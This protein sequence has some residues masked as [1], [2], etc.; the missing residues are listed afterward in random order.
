LPHPP[1]TLRETAR[2]EM[3]HLLACDRPGLAS[4]PV[5]FHEGLAEALVGLQPTPFFDYELSILGSSWVRPLR[6][7]ALK[8]AQSSRPL[9]SVL[10]EQSAEVRY[11]ALACLVQLVLN[12]VHGLMPW[13]DS[14]AKPTVNGFLSRLPSDYGSA[15][16]VPLPHGRELDFYG[17]GKDILMASL[18][19][20]SVLLQVG[21][22]TGVQNLDFD[23]RVGRTGA[24]M[25]GVI[26]RSKA[27]P[28]RVVRVR[29]NTFGAVVA[30]LESLNQANVRAYQ[31]RPQPGAVADWREFS[32]ELVESVD[33]L[34]RLRISSREYERTFPREF[35]PPYTLE[36]YVTD[37]ACQVRADQVLLPPDN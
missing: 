24:A 10:V 16:P 30:S 21:T 13:N 17:G 26:L 25:A 15:D 32:M 3:V 23:L 8:P 12:Q 9:H 18:P 14:Y 37:G 20:E 6:E 22:W 2:H 31:S 7:Y 34:P 19:S 4:A 1:R 29:M 11:S 28:K 5:W 36:F 35:S 27:D 33:G